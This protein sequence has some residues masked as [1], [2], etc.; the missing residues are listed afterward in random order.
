MV[1]LPRSDAIY[2]LDVDSPLK[3]LSPLILGC[4][5][6]P[7]FGQVSLVSK[8]PK[9]ERDLGWVKGDDSLS[10]NLDPVF[11]DQHQLFSALPQRT[12]LAQTPG[13]YS[14]PRTVTTR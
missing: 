12:Q 14:S 9:R 8:G 6:M 4:S 1:E 5:I 11:R 2:L 7:H 13:S 10:P 3:A